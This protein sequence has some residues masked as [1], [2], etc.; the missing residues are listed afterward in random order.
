MA[1]PMQAA[2][3]DASQASAGPQRTRCGGE[4]G[5]LVGREV[6]HAV[7]DH[8]AEALRLDGWPLDV[9][10]A[11]VDVAEARFNRQPPGLGELLLGHVDTDHPTIRPHGKG[12]QEAVGPGAA[13]KVEYRLTRFHRR[14]VEEIAH[15]GERVNRRGRDAVELVGGI[16]KP[17]GQGPAR[18]EVEVALG[19]E[20]HLL[21]HALHALLELGRVELLRGGRHAAVSLVE[22][23]CRLC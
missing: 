2:H 15:A 23:E 18:L 3:S 21:V 7:R 1:P 11:E 8:T 16:A 4:H 9:A 5:R 12:R 14:H 17:L 6:D 10:N 20:R 13:A 22:V 19:L